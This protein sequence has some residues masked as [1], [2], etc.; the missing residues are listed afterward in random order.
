VSF[1]FHGEGPVRLL[2]NSLLTA[3]KH[4]VTDENF[5]KLGFGAVRHW[6]IFN[7]RK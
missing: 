1:I 6:R 5:N 2:S 3:Y 4:T 7:F